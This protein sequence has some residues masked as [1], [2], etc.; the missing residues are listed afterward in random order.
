VLSKC[1]WMDPRG[2][3]WKAGWLRTILNCFPS[4]NLIGENQLSHSS[5]SIK[6]T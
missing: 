5:D 2:S 3:A 6:I 4:F 1:W